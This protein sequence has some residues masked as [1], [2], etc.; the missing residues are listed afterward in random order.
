MKA[1]VETGKIYNNLIT[2][3]LCVTKRNLV[4]LAAWVAATAVT[5]C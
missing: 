3:L 4:G 2:V 5:G 1:S